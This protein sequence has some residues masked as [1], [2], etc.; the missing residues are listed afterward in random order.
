MKRFS[1]F[2]KH[3][4]ALSWGQTTKVKENLPWI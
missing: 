2:K 4:L 3:I 1:S